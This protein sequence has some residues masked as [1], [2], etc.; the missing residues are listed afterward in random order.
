MCRVYDEENEKKDEE[1]GYAVSLKRANES[2]Q[3][4]GVEEQP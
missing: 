4:N 2:V 3:R 1:M